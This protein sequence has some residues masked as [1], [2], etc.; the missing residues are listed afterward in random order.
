LYNHFR[1][2]GIVS[3]KSAAM[4]PRREWVDNGAEPIIVSSNQF[5]QI[6]HIDAE[7]CH[8]ECTLADRNYEATTAQKVTVEQSIRDASHKFHLAL[9]VD[10]PYWILEYVLNYFDGVAKQISAGVFEVSKPAPGYRMG[11]KLVTAEA[12]NSAQVKVGPQRRRLG[13]PVQ[14]SQRE[15]FVAN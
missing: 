13:H 12:P 5:V 6:V 7:K 4:R 2:F 14:Q 10:L 3:N 8:I 15:R 1:E 9:E 11:R